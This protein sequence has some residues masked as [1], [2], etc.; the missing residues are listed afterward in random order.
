MWG[1][2]LS[3]PYGVIRGEERSS[4]NIKD[5]STALPEDIPDFLVLPAA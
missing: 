2:A 3:G 4:A 5:V 1:A